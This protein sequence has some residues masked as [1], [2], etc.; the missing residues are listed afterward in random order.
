MVE[1]LK[2]EGYLVGR[3]ISRYSIFVERKWA[4]L[5]KKWSIAQNSILMVD[6]LFI[7]NTTIIVKHTVKSA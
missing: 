5:K 3:E 4:S 1:L 7:L 6:V 2:R